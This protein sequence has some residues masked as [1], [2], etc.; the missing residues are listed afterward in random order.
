MN[1]REVL[2]GLAIAMLPIASEAKEV[3]EEPEEFLRMYSQPYGPNM[4]FEPV[5]GINRERWHLKGPCGDVCRPTYFIGSRDGR[6]FEIDYPARNYH[7]DSNFWDLLKT[8][9]PKA[10]EN[11]L[12]LLQSQ[13]LPTDN[14]HFVIDDGFIKATK[15][16]KF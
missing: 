10:L 3:S 8:E 15:N 2:S 9:E 6:K 1:R 4:W 5:V 11:V 16:R 14:F 12:K 13:L 7:D